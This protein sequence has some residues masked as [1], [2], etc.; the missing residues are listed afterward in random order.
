[1]TGLETVYAE[2]LIVQGLCLWIYLQ[3]S[4]L[5]YHMNHIND[6]FLE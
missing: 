2:R 1:V 6:R 3:S 5:I 4:G